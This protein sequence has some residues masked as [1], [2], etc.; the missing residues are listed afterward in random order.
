MCID[1]WTV[2]DLTKE[3]GLADQQ[4]D[5][6]EFPKQRGAQGLVS[7]GKAMQVDGLFSTGV[8]I[9]S[10]CM[11]WLQDVGFVRE[12]LPSVLK[13]KPAAGGSGFA[14]MLASVFTRSVTPSPSTNSTRTAVDPPKQDPR[15][16]LS[17][18]MT[19]QIY[20]ADV[21]VTLER[22]LEKE[23]ERATKKLPPK[24]TSLQLIFSELDSQSSESGNDTVNGIFAGLKPE[25]GGKIFIGQA[26]GQ[27]TG[28]GGHI[29]ARFIPTVERESIDLMDRWVSVWNRELLYV[30][31]FVSRTVYEIQMRRLGQ[32]WPGTAALDSEDAAVKEVVDALL[33]QA[34]HTMKYFTFKPST[35]SA[36]VAQTME[37][38]F[39]TSLGDKSIPII[40]TKGIRGA[41]TVRLPHDMLNNFLPNLPIFAPQLETKVEMFVARLRERRLLR[42]I[43]LEDVIEQLSRNPLTETQMLACFDWWKQLANLPQYDES[44]RRRLLQAA[45]FISKDAETGSDRIVSV[46]A[47]QTYLNPAMIPTEVPLPPHTAPYTFTKVLKANDMTTVFGWKEL[48][49]PVWIQSIDQKQVFTSEDTT[50][51]VFGVLGR[52]WPRL[53]NGHKEE[54]KVLLADVTCIPTTLGFRKPGETYHKEV[55]LFEDLPIITFPHLVVRGSIRN[56][57]DALGVRSVVDLQLIFTR[58]IGKSVWGVHDLARYLSSVRKS[59]STHEFNRLK[60]TAAFPVWSVEGEATPVKR[61]TPDALCE[62]TLENKDLGVRCLDYGTEHVWK[63][64]SAEALLLFELGLRRHPAASELLRLASSSNPSQQQKALK[65]LFKNIRQY[66]GFDAPAQAADIA[67]IPARTAAGAHI[68]AKPTEVFINRRSA[69]IGCHTADGLTDEE[70]GKLKLL[71][72]PPTSVIVQFLTHTPPK[73]VPEGA[74]VFEYLTS[75]LLDLKRDGAIRY[76]TK[77][78]IPTES[79]R[80]V[81]PSQAFFKP[82]DDRDETFQ[83]YKNVYDFV[84]FGLG[85]TF[86]EV[87]GVKAQPTQEQVARMIVGDPYGAKGRLA[88]NDK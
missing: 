49:I 55:S 24:R 7:P 9:S 48:T 38:A 82:K 85:D 11:S 56:M 26:T 23:L 52:A 84:D 6:K 27:T 43:S 64:T 66:P 70:L 39:Y 78:F 4:V 67:F 21:K 62:P 22:A 40:S 61:T 30:A 45:V 59:L 71:Q 2:L 51:Q 42:E 60:K 86:L 68:L 15:A 50:D 83:L 10:K 3:I 76:L 79:G 41:E 69:V 12:P 35:P 1:G 36:Q 34:E 8:R 77:P 14:S 87:C 53:S 58:L 81:L 18:S 65:Y 57:L 19:L 46:G 13:P 74:A 44:V 33:R 63:S 47:L 25:T 72:E 5:L 54:V 17:N 88:S 31:G 20:R 37:A 32:M 28:I 29:A 73:T 16:I 80:L 75:R